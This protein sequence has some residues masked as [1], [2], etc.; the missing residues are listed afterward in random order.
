MF[1]FIVG[2]VLLFLV[3]ILFTSSRSARKS[4]QNADAA[5]PLMFGAIACGVLAVISLSAST[6]VHVGDDEVGLVV[7]QMGADLPPGQIIARNGEKGPQARIL[8]PGWHLWYWPWNYDIIKSPLVNIPGGEVGVVVASDGRSLPRGEIFAPEFKSSDEMLDAERFLNGDGCKG[9]Q[10]TIL[11]PG[12]YRIN[13]RLFTVTMHPILTV[14]VGEVVVVKANSGLAPSEKDIQ[15]TV[16]GLPLV[17]KGYRGIWK[18]PLQPGQYYLH[19][20]AYSTIHVRTV[21]RVYDYAEAANPKTSDPILVR[22]KDGFTFPVDIRV[23][24]SVAASDAPYMVALLADPDAMVPNSEGPEKEA[25]CTLEA[26]LILPTIKTCLRNVAENMTA[27]EFVDHR[28][29]VEK[30]A[31]QSMLNEMKQFRVTTEGL[32]I[33]QIDFDHNDATK[34]LMKTRTDKELAISQQKT[35]V[36]Q[37]KAQQ[38]RALVMKSTEE[39][40]Q[41]KNVVAAQ[42]QVEVTQQKAIARKAEAQGEAQYIEITAKARKTAYE[43]MSKPLGQDGVTLLEV[44]KLIGEKGIQITPQI[45]VGGGDSGSGILK[46]LAGTMLRDSVSKSPMQ[47]A[48]VTKE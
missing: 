39:A 48:P 12:K 35:Y 43:E 5:G 18:D 41:Q 36:E 33:G 26:R 25:I 44:L 14:G 19:P 32:F 13:P 38:Q 47:A 24:V 1:W 16:N 6:L 22:S 37:D 23:G 28:S 7:K 8:G 10:L 15:Q 42:F 29:E 31:T 3:P 17:P 45:M 11:T 2:L 34:L 21:N 4:R 46:A 20:D 40:E 9:P 27:L 30:A